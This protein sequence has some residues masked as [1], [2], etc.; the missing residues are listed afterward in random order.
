MQQRVLA[1]AFGRFIQEVMDSIQRTA[2][3]EGKNQIAK[4]ELVLNLTR[5]ELRSKVEEL[6]LMGNKFELEITKFNK[7][8]RDQDDVRA[9]ERVVQSKDKK[10]LC[11][12]IIHRML[13]AHLAAA[14]DGFCLAIHLR[15]AHRNTVMKAIGRWRSGL[16]KA[17]SSWVDNAKDLRRKRNLLERMNLR[18]RSVFYHKAWASWDMHVQEVRR[19]QG[20][21]QKMALQRYFQFHLIQYHDNDDMDSEVDSNSNSNSDSDSH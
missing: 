9:Y 18:M 8:L 17:W 2:Q 15:V 6:N 5:E 3:Q 16:Y 12:R 21:L 19:L 20:L 13:Q 1:R 14:F 7:V 4:A 11:T 10:F